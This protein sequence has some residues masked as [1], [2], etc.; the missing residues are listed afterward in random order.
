MRKIL[1]VLAVALCLVAIQTTANA[2]VDIR[3]GGGLIFDNTVPGGG[4]AVDIALTESIQISPFADYF[5]KNSTDII[6]LGV[7]VK[8]TGPLGESDALFYVGVGGGMVRVDTGTS[9][10]KLLIDAVGGIDYPATE[11]IYI[12]MEGRYMWAA[13]DALNDVAAFA[14][15]KFSVGEK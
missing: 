8:L 3:V 7:N 11:K 15:I 6:P 14:G 9:V 1:V 13:D 5:H 4:A 10:N 12:Y 2:Q